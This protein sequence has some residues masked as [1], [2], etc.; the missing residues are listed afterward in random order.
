[1]PREFFDRKAQP[2]YQEWLAKPLDERLA[3][4]AVGDANV[5]AERVYRHW[6]SHDPSKLGGA[7]N[8]GEYRAHLA[9]HECDDFA[10][11]RDVADTHKHV[12]LDRPTRRVTSAD[13]TAKGTL[14]FGE[15][16]Y[17]EGVYGGGGQLIVELDDGSKRPLTAIMKNVDEMWERLLAGWGM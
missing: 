2:N 7:K 6:E 9:K 13:Q 15:A 10:L 11:V 8:A 1:M 4:N 3:S 17:S 5:M 16:R 12:T 14:G